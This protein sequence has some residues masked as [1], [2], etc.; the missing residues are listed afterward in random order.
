MVVAARAAIR[1]RTHAQHPL[2]SGS[3]YKVQESEP[4]VAWSLRKVRLNVPNTHQKVRVID[5]VSWRWRKMALCFRRFPQ[6]LFVLKSECW[7]EEHTDPSKVRARGRGGPGGAFSAVGI[8]VSPALPHSKQP[9]Q[10]QLATAGGSTKV[11]AARSPD[12]RA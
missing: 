12:D 3:S 4:D 7:G 1:R 10:P 2:L 6:A 8:V 9:V 11:W 5:I